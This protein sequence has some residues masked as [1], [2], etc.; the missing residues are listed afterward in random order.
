LFLE[1]IGAIRQVSTVNIGVRER[2]MENKMDVLM[3]VWRSMTL[4]TM[5]SNLGSKNSKKAT[6]ANCPNTKRA[7]EN[8]SVNMIICLD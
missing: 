6:N 8:K 7:I 2:V 3:P 4:N 1:T 5:R